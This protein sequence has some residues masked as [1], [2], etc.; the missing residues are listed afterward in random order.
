MGR[1]A[2]V[3]STTRSRLRDCLNDVDF[4]ATEDDLVQ[5]AVRNRCDEDT[6]RA[7]RA[8]PPKTYGNLSEVLASVPFADD[9]LSDAEKAAARRVHTKPGLAESAKESRRSPSPRNWAKTGKPE[10]LTLSARRRPTR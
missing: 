3:A 8:I 9:R 10:P 6:A 7:L 4:P 5:A 1:I 2:M